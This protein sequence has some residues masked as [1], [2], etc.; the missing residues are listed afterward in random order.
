MDDA[1]LDEPEPDDEL[2]DDESE[3][4]GVELSLLAVSAGL[5]SPADFVSDERLSVR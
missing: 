1:E 4:L 3:A 2:L 5:V